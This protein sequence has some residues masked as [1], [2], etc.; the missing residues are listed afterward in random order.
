LSP[1]FKHL[2]VQ[3]GV[4]PEKI[5]VIYNWADR[6]AL[7][8]A[9]GS[10]PQGS[11]LARPSLFKVL[12]AGNMGHA[13]ALDSVLDA[14]GLHQARA[15]RVVFIF[16]GAGVD[17]ERLQERAAG[18][19]LRNVEFLP[20]VPMSE[21]GTYLAAADVLLVHLRDDP[22]FAVTIPSKTQAYMAAGKAI[23]LAVRGDAAELLLAAGGGVAI[24]PE[25]PEALA[26]ALGELASLPLDALAQM[27]TKSRNYYEAHLSIE[28]GVDRFGRIFRQVIPN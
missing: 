18:L 3:R 16:V 9:T 27:G 11:L 26:S 28:H 19:M 8:R 12:F 24:P 21:V 2:L 20:S 10:V 23:V 1:G 13:Q 22:L 17:C 7:V 25:N 6:E 4:P 5:E 14:A 15:S